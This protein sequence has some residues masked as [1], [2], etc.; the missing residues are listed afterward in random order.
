MD[1]ISATIS[2]SAIAQRTIAIAPA[3]TTSPSE[4]FEER[5]EANAHHAEPPPSNETTSAASNRSVYYLVDDKTGALVFQMRRETDD[6]VLFQIPDELSLRLRQL[7]D[8]QQ[9]SMSAKRALSDTSA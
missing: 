6:A 3:P 2:L 4:K 1:K 7:Y 8:E 5:G 9:R